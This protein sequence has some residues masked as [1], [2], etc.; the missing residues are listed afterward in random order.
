VDSP[1]VSASGVSSDRN[2]SILSST[3]SF[4]SIYQE[5]KKWTDQALMKKGLL[6]FGFHIYYE[7]RTPRQDTEYI[8]R[9]ID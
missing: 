5:Q 6:G 1:S 3:I 9:V 8:D 4:A 7:E 2:G